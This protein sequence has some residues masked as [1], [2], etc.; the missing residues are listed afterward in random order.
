MQV[1]GV[2]NIHCAG[3]TG[4]GYTSVE[5]MLLDL[6]GEL[7]IAPKESKME[8]KVAFDTEGATEANVPHP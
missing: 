1:Y 5:L 3:V 4:R 8:W 7:R 2:I 6:K